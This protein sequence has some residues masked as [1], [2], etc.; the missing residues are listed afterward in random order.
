MMDMDQHQHQHHYSS[1]HSSILVL[2]D[3]HIRRLHEHIYNSFVSDTFNIH[4]STDVR[5]LGK[6]GRTI[7]KLKKQDLFFVTA[8]KPD[9][10]FIHIGGNDLTHDC[11]YFVANNLLSL[12]N[13]VLNFCKHVI[14]SQQNFRYG[15]R[16]SSFYNYNV[17]LFNDHMHSLVSRHPHIHFWEHEQRFN[18]EDGEGFLLDGVHYNWEGNTRFYYSVKRCLRLAVDGRWWD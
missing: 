6:G 14:I 4:S 10:C 9:I 16:I 2:G 1:P 5:F 18:G 11:P 3:S 15:N 13:Y 17:S 8:L 7:N 12:C